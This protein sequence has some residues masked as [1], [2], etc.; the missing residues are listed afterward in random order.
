MTTASILAPID[1]FAAEAHARDQL[2]RVALAEADNCPAALRIIE[3]NRP[4][5]LH[6]GIAGALQIVAGPDASACKRYAAESIIDHRRHIAAGGKGEL[7]LRKASAWR[8]LAAERIA[9]DRAASEAS[10]PMLLAAE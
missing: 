10:R 5:R 9:E 1:R 4:Q 2:R 7:W 6:D 8:W 3:N